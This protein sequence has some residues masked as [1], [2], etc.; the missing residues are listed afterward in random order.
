MLEIKL[1]TLRKRAKETYTYINKDFITWLTKHRLN[2]IGLS[3]FTSSMATE[4]MDSLIMEKKLSGRTHNDRL[5]IL[6]VFYNAM[7]EREWI[8]KNPFKK[9]KAKPVEIGRNLAFSEKEQ[10]KLKKHLYEH[11]RQM[12]Y[13]TQVIYYCFIRRSELLQLQV[14]H[15][16]LVNHTIIIPADISKN[17]CSE[18]VVIPVGLEEILLEMRLQHHSPDD[19]VIG[20]GLQRSFRMIKNINHIST[21]HNKVA[22]KLGFDPDK[23][24]YSWKHT[25]ACRAYYAT[26][27]DIYSLMRQLRHRDLNTTMIYLKSLGLVQNEV[28]RSAMVA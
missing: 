5:I 22:S 13:F 8:H 19:Y 20:H 6:K 12:Y 26:G 4:Y 28:F 14:G 3:E 25:G 1:P 18:T 17:K 23:G 27:K 2:N 9:I 16:D 10:E 11:D 7:M 15:F 24:L 21:R